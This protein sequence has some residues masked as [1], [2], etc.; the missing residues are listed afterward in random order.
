[1]CCHPRHAEHQG[2][3]RKEILSCLLAVLKRENSSYWLSWKREQFWLAELGER[4]VLIGWAEESCWA[5]RLEERTDLIGWAGRENNSDWLSWIVTS[6]RNDQSL[7]MC[8]HHRHAGLQGCKREQIWL[9]EKGERTV[10]IGW[11]GRGNNS[12]SLSWEREQFWLAELRERTV[13][14][15]LVGCELLS[16][17]RIV[18]IGWVDEWRHDVI[19]RHEKQ[20]SS[21]WK[22]REHLSNL[23]SH[24]DNVTHQGISISQPCYEEECMECN[25]GFNS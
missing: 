13:L 19:I 14:I 18:L 2:C 10:L 16:W 1:M 25:S 22:C 11:V 4:T 20:T 24:H 15:G 5:P 6:W 12:G 9:A 3:K 21:Q 23:A 8:C 17:E 7:C